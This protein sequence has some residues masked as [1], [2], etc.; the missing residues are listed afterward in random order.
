MPSTPHPLESS[1]P[2]AGETRARIPGLL[3][4]LLLAVLAAL[5]GRRALA[6]M[7]HPGFVAHPAEALPAAEFP[8]PIGLPPATGTHMGL[9]CPILYAIGPGP[10]QGLSPRPRATPAAHP[11]IARAPPLPC[12]PS[13]QNPLPWGPRTCVVKITIS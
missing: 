6:P 3:E 13:R 10:N 12:T 4:T 2:R 9:D 5:F 11:R 1:C 8:S 7:W